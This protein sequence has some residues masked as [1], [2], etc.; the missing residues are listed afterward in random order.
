MLYSHRVLE[1]RIHFIELVRLNFFDSLIAHAKVP[2]LFYIGLFLK[3]FQFSSY[4]LID[5]FI[6]IFFFLFQEFNA[7]TLTKILIIYIFNIHIP[8]ILL[9]LS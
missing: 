9:Q 1:N 3:V 5:F 7:V 6:I 4:E 8:L 2:V